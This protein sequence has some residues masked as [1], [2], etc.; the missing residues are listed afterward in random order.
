MAT[1]AQLRADLKL[2]GTVGR[3]VIVA[4]S[5]V[6]RKLDLRVRGDDTMVDDVRVPLGLVGEYGKAPHR[7]STWSPPQSF[8]HGEALVRIGLFCAGVGIVSRLSRDRID[9]AMLLSV[10]LDSRASGG[11]P[12]RLGVTGSGSLEPEPRERS[13]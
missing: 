13:A 6:A 3:A 9:E 2:G 4:S 7:E 12:P 8:S 1:S 10:E 11:V 5:G